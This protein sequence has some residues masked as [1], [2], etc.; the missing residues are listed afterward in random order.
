MHRGFINS[1]PLFPR[2]VYCI[3]FINILFPFLAIFYGILF[4]FSFFVN[5][6]LGDA[7]TVLIAHVSE[8]ET[9]KQ[10]KKKE[11]D[12]KRTMPHVHASCCNHMHL[13]VLIVIYTI[14]AFS[15]QSSF[16]LN[17]SRRVRML[18]YA[19]EESFELETK[20]V[21]RIIFFLSIFVQHVFINMIIMFLIFIRWRSVRC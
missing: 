8:A 10:S 15:F 1:I 20:S 19:P 3:D 12:I 14:Q 18:L 13:F 17:I 4:S 7:S 5:I 11:E 6:G 2:K 21:S 9:Q 16:S